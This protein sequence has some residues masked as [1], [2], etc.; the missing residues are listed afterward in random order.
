MK[1]LP[2]LCLM[3]LLH[4]PAAAASAQ[5]TISFLGGL[6]LTVIASQRQDDFIS[7]GY[8]RTAGMNVGFAASY[9]VS[10]PDANETLSF[11]LAGTYTQKGALLGDTEDTR[12]LDYLELALLAD[13]RFPSIVDGIHIHF[14]AGP[15]VG[16]LL[17]CALSVG[18]VEGQDAT[19]LPCESGQF[20]ARDHSIA[21]GAG[22]E[23]A[24]T[25]TIHVTTTFLYTIG[26]G[27]I[28]QIVGV[29]GEDTGSLKN[30]ALTVRAA[31][32]FPIG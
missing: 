32:G 19:S 27:Y 10:P 18:G 21:A 1:R 7:A 4:L 2:I 3:A 17:S 23:F 20:R 24:L 5:H 16:W 11:Q 15:A 22:L 31:L 30:R 26:L 12:D 14:V 28:D 8:Q 6:N 29:E 9:M 13:M 25:E